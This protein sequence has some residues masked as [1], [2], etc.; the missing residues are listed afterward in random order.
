MIFPRRNHFA[1]YLFGLLTN[2]KLPEGREREGKRQRQRER[3]SMH[4]FFESLGMNLVL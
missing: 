2:I 3:E 4:V 1:N